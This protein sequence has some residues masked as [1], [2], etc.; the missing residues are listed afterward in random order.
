MDIIWVSLEN[1]NKIFSV[2][3]N[4]IWIYYILLHLKEIWQIV[5]RRILC[6]S[7]NKTSNGTMGKI[8]IDEIVIIGRE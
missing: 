8:N 7:K 5:Y 1:I 6:N 3:Y 4:K 2:S